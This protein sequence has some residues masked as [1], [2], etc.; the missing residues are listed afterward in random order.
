[1][2]LGVDIIVGRR[3]STVHERNSP[4]SNMRRRDYSHVVWTLHHARHE[5]LEHGSYAK[6]CHDGRS[7]CPERCEH[8][9]ADLG[10]GDARNSRLSIRGKS[11]T[12]AIFDASSRFDLIVQTDRSQ[13]ITFS[14]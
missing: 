11:T 5:T 12:N 3:C 4:R 1:M 2:R 6:H 7:V 9:F 14:N 8:V 10:G 13:L